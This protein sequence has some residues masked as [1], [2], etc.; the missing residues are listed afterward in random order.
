[1]KAAEVVELAGCGPFGEPSYEIRVDEL[2]GGVVGCDGGRGIAF[3][4]F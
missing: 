4:F 1:M 3:P 2:D